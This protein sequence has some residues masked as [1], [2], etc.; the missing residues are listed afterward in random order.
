MEQWFRDA[1]RCRAL[2]PPAGR[3]PVEG[4]DTAIPQGIGLRLASN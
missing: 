4:E 3:K 2:G 1:G